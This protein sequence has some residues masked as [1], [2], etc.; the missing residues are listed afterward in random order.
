M[1]VLGRV[2]KTIYIL[3]YLHEQDLRRRDDFN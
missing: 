2:V 1:T 3:R